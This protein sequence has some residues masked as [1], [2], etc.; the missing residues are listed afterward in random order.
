MLCSDQSIPCQFSCTE[1]KCGHIPRE[2]QEDC[3]QNMQ[4][5]C[6]VLKSE[7]EMMKLRTFSLILS[8]SFK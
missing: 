5:S 3:R 4:D 7:H 8:Y 2:M 6:E 1:Q